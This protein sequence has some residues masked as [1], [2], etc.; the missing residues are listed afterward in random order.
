[1]TLLKYSIRFW[2]KYFISKA[3]CVFQKRKKNVTLRDAKEDVD[4]VCVKV[5]KHAV[6]HFNTKHL[7]LWTMPKTLE[8][9]W[10]NPWK[11]EEFE[12]GYTYEK[13][14]SNCPMS[15]KLSYLCQ[16]TKLCVSHR[17][18]QWQKVENFRLVF[19]R[20]IRSESTRDKA[21]SLPPASPNYVMLFANF[22]FTSIQ[23]IL[24]QFCYLWLYFGIDT[25]SRPLLQYPASRVAW[26]FRR[27][28]A[29]DCKDWK[30]TET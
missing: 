12:V 20:T 6:S 9:Q 30:W 23:K 21:G 24:V 28:V 25:V 5:Q 11:N 13:S 14:I 8:P 4:K 3:H 18:N 10:R 15:I 2:N 27:W 26:N 17:C 29:M 1:M 16:L 19:Q 22:F 7:V